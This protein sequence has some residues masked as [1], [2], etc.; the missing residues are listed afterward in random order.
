MSRN[1]KIIVIVTII[2]VVTI[3]ISVLISI[4]KKDINTTIE[5]NEQ[6]RILE[7]EEKD[8][9]GEEKIE[10]E[11]VEVNNSEIGIEK[12]TTENN[13]TTNNKPTTNNTHQS[14]NTNKPSINNTQQSA[15][16]NNST[17]NNTQQPANKPSTNNNQTT[18]N[19]NNNQTTQNTDNSQSS[20]EDDIKK[21]LE[22]TTKKWFIAQYNVSKQQYVNTLNSSIPEKKRQIDNLEEQAKTLYKNYMQEVKNIN[23]RYP[24]SETKNIMLRNAQENYSNSAKAYTN[25]INSLENEIGTLEAEIKNPNV[26]SIL[27]IVAR[28]CNISSK[29][30]HEYYNKYL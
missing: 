18:I 27:S 3:G 11:E 5:E 4:T 6:E 24:D 14:S 20:T 19:T 21:E 10:Q 8:N 26:D 15:D 17:T 13:Q 22:E 1:K 9:I 16:T 7:P 23:S 28:N 25:Q 29:E 12:P 30:A 2:V